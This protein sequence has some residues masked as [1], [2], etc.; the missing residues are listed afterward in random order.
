LID[1]V[2]LA[3]VLESLPTGLNHVIGDGGRLLSGGQRQRVG[4]ARALFD[5][6]KLLILDEGTSALDWLTEKEVIES[7][8]K[9]QRRVTVIMIS[10]KVSRTFLADKV[11]Y[12]NSGRIEY[13]GNFATFLKLYP[14]VITDEI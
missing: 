4:L 14:G 3:E 5:E 10:H 7:I 12:L 11:I 2:S 9:L 8:N 13:Q 1:L 6:P